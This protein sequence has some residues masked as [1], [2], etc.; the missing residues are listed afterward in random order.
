MN[1]IKEKMQLAAALVFLLVFGW[2]MIYSL[3]GKAA[4]MPDEEFS[5]MFTT[6]DA[7]IKATSAS[8]EQTAKETLPCVSTETTKQEK[9]ESRYI[10]YNIPL[11]DDFQEYIQ[12]I[13][14]KY[15]FDRYDVVIALIEEESLYTEKIISTTNDY[16]YM[17]INICNHEWLSEKLEINDF[18]NGKQNVLAGTYLLSE[19]YKKYGDIELA[20]MAYGCGEKGAAELWEQGIYKTKQSQTVLEIAKKLTL[21]QL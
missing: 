11:D 13:C 10:Y 20:L 2:V 19:L 4:N 1:K 9:S 8:I 5:P 7:E 14:E 16:G 15:D 21:K 12:D 17:Q 18:L 3:I 6:E